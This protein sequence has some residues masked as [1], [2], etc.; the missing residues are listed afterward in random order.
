MKALIFS[1]L[2]HL[3][4]N[5]SSEWSTTN[6]LSRFFRNNLSAFILSFFREIVPLSSLSS[7]KKIDYSS[8]QIK[9]NYFCTFLH[10]CCVTPASPVR[11]FIETAYLNLF[12]FLI[13]FSTDSKPSFLRKSKKCF[14]FL[15]R[16][17]SWCETLFR[18]VLVLLLTPVAATAES[19]ATLLPRMN[20]IRLCSK[21][22]IL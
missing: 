2:L 11:D 10:N 15:K 6:E 16:N 3:I 22:Q 20:S 1:F 5:L 7:Y 14:E 18:I 9:W 8:W 12:S 19:G 21:S 17:T 4:F 13:N